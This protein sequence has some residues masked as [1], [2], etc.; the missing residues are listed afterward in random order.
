MRLT[1]KERILLHLLDCVQSAD[2]PEVPPAMTQEGVARAAGIQRRHLAQFVRP[3]IAEG[4][5][6]E[7]QAHVE[8]IRQR[9]KVYALTSEGR[10]V[11]G[12]MRAE[13]DDRVVRVRDGGVVTRA[14]IHDALQGV[15][16]RPT[17]LEAV[18]QVEQSGVLDLE[19][20]RHPPDSGLVELTGD[21]PRIR[22]FVGRREELAE[23]LEEG[24][25][26][27]IFVVRGVAG[28]GKTAFAAKVCELLR[29]R[30]NLFWHRIRPWEST[31]A[32]LAG[33]ARFLELLDR[34]GL[35]SLLR[36]GQAGMAPEVL[37]QD[38]PATHSVL[39]FDDA[40]EASTETLGFFRMIS[41]AVV[42]SPDV[43][44]LI[45]TRR[46]LPF[47]DV[48]DVEIRR[49]IREIELRG[50]ESDEAAALL[51]DGEDSSRLIGLGRRLAGHPLFIDLVRSHDY[52]VSVA[53]EDVER[54]IEES[55]YRALS[56]SEKTTMKGASLYEVPVPRETLL[57]IPGSSFEVLAS[58]RDRSLLRFVGG[59][60]YEV[61]DTIRDFFR[62]ILTPAESRKFAALAVDRLRELAANGRRVGDPNSATAYLSNALRL[63]HQPAER[64]EIQE[65]LG[66][67]EARM[68]DL[69]GSLVWYRDSLRGL[70]ERVIAARLHRKLAGVLCSLGETSAASAEALEAR[71]AL[72]DRDPVEH[73]W[74]EL[75]R[76]RIGIA[77]EDWPQA[78]DHAEAAI[79]GFRSCHEV[80]GQAE[81][82]IE[83]AIVH[84]N[85]RSGSPSSAKECLEEA[86]SLSKST[87]DPSLAA[88]AEVQFA[89]LY[90][91]RLGDADRATEHLRA[92]EALPRSPFD[93]R[94]RQSL[95]MLEGWLNLDLRA[96][97][98][99]AR[100]KFDEAHTLSTKLHDRTSA[101]LAKHGAAMTAY[102][103]GDWDAAL[104]QL[105]E[106]APQLLAAGCAGPSFEAQY[107]S[108]EISLARGNLAD[109]R[110]RM[111]LMRD[112]GLA[113]GLEVRPVLALAI[114][115]IRAFTEG[116]WKGVHRAFEAAIVLAEKEGSPLERS[117]LSSTHDTY[118]AVLQAMG[119]DWG[120]QEQERIAVES[121][122]RFGLKGRLAA[123]VLVIPRLA[124][125]LRRL[126]PVAQTASP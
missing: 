26:S 125:S 37:R 88:N 81:A 21:A 120:A 115:G 2:D 98:Q 52:D 16:T 3:L 9:R 30:R 32:L 40:H 27:R 29:G 104:V 118:G 68:G 8:G 124:D 58:L 28:I 6:R 48:R 13:L 97:F 19:A 96:D 50:L 71:S 59:D 80:R 51:A 107:S 72:G 113:R 73:G 100:A 110:R 86:L 114:R 60:R 36:R 33:L 44:T 62:R 93:I 57:S 117:L 109:F 1:V 35:A 121:A 91:Y 55:V 122:E 39:V 75:V 17:L 92:I 42:S 47:Y 34:P 49:V 105:D 61:H 126:M 15:G 46:A 23:V 108:A 84:I 87:P 111:E 99:T 82:L 22:V 78:K 41:E 79:E 63:S 74:L 64:R 20:I 67:A 12:R 77:A 66:D 4:L 106:A 116:D 70:T 43:R 76:S 56:R 53:S 5:V 31:E 119:H 102:Q 25:A 83:L 101:A 69:P 45:L 89:N 112:P 38:L 11:A 7:R 90:A 10:G 85:A 103:S 54:F 123:R 14:S 95:L 94:T 65:A 24:G 18:R